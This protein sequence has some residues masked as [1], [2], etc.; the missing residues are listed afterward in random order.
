MR[1]FSALNRQIRARFARCGRE[2]PSLK[3]IQSAILAA[4]PPEA[5]ECRIE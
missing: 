5:G 2:L 3:A 4:K 1:R